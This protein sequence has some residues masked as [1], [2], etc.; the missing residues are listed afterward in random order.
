MQKNRR[1]FYT[2]AP[3]FCSAM[4][5]QTNA[6]DFLTKRILGFSFHGKEARAPDHTGN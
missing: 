6:W 1:F 4:A 3:G 2:F 5:E